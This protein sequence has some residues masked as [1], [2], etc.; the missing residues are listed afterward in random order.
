MKRILNKAKSFEEAEEYDIL[1]NINM[2]FYRRHRISLLLK[3]RFFGKKI[4][5]LRKN[6]K[7]KKIKVK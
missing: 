1:Q 7:F 2:P 4:K 6:G 5:D 3:K